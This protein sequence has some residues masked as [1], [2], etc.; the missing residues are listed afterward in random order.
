MELYLHFYVQKRL[1]IINWTGQL[2][3]SFARS[4]ILLFKNELNISIHFSRFLAFLANPP[5]TGELN[6]LCGHQIYL[7]I[8]DS[9]AIA[10]PNHQF[11]K[12]K[13]HA[14]NILRVFPYKVHITYTEQKHKNWLC[15]IKFPK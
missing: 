5:S 11:Q 13:S 12:H 15:R 9:V 4:S 3:I 8:I 2:F 10:I 1:F 6:R 14:C 7:Q